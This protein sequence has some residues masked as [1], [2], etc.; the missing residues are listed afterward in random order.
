MQLTTSALDAMLKAKDYEKGTLNER[1][2]K[3]IGAQLLTKEMGE[4]AHHV[5]LGANDQRHADEDVGFPTQ[6]DAQQSIEFTEALAEI[7]FV[8]PKTSQT[9]NR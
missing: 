7:L 5:R 6:E 3:A 8:L 2:K 9:S 4:W 1:I